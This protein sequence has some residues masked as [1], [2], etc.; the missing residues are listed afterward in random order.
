MR[1]WH[2][3]TD[4]LVC[5]VCRVENL[6]GAQFCSNCGRTLE[7]EEVSLRGLSRREGQGALIDFPPPTRPSAV[8]GV[9]GLVLIGL[10]VLGAGTWFLLRPDPCAGKFAS[11]QFPYCMAVPRGW[12]GSQQVIQDIPFDAFTR[13]AELPMVVVTAG[14][15]QPGMDTQAYADAQRRSLE[16]DGLFPS[17]IEQDEVGGF[18]ALAWETTTTDTD[19]TVLRERR[20]TLVRD[21]QGWIIL[22]ES[23]QQDYRQS[24][25]QF[26]DMLET[27]SWT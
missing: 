9:I 20:I 15:T 23:S 8:P 19:G 17:P 6:E 1:P 5:P 3:S 27:W 4:V 12:E 25:T 11:T 21:G 22:L 10:F 14:N 13:R 16:A 24:L 26:R 7:P 18:E 2:G